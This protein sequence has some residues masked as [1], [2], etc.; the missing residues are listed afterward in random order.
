MAL[1]IDPKARGLKRETET[2]IGLLGGLNTFQDQTVIRDSELTEA[3]NIVLDVDGIE[4]RYG[5]VN[6]GND[7]S[8]SLI[9]GL[10]SAYKSDGTRK[11]LRVSGG[12]LKYLNGNSW[13]QIGST[14]FANTETSIIQARDKVLFFN[15]TNDLRVYDFSSITTYTALTTPVGLTVTPTGTAQTTAYSYRV[16]AFNAQGETLACVAVNTSTGHAT[17]STTNYNKLDWTAVSGAVGYNIWGRKATGLT[18]TYMT[19]VYTNTYNDTGE[20]TPSTTILPPE[21]NNTGGIKGK[22]ACFGISRIFV[23]GDAD[24]P[25]RLYWGG[26]GTNLLNFSGA[27]EG[28]GYVDVFKNDG[29]DI[30][31][32]IP[33]Q[34]GVIVGKTNAIYKFSFVSIG[35]GEGE[36]YPKLE[37]I[38]KSF[39]MISHYAVKHVENDLIFPAKKDGRLAFYSLGNVENFS[40]AILRTN[41]L[42][43]KNAS[44]LADVNLSRLN[45]AQA[46]YYR[47]IYGCAISTEGSTVNDRIWC[48][49][50][51]FGAWV[52]WE[53]MTP[54]CFSEFTDTDGTQNLYYGS[55]NTGYVVK[56]FQEARNDNGVAVSTQF[57]TKSFNQKLPHKIKNYYS[58]TFIFKGVNKSAAISGDIVLDG[59]VTEEDF[60]VASTNLGGAGFGSMLFGQAVFGT[61]TGG[62]AGENTASDQPTELDRTYEARSIKYRF[63]TN[64]VDL[65]FKLL[66]FSHD[67]EVTN[68]PLNQNYRRY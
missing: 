5:T 40:S 4:P 1:L 53:G 24:N 23:A 13:T 34:G 27:P 62:T 39:G 9:Y 31:A 44:E 17:L 35:D 21:G 7:G 6:Y 36:V 54:N 29:Q 3:K 37:E 22:Y 45:K 57:A 46:F 49:D 66:A 2:I 68:T 59:N 55:G 50:T 58:P 43:I 42:S 30:T 64:V 56:M 65:Y 12:Y 19:T 14:A 10:F 28:G 18:Q 48:L 15:G 41:E 11:F 8:D 16:S 47:N 32:I 63:R 33:F 25:S 51:R 38:T 52:Y 61:A 20:Y 60:L 67:Y 26:V